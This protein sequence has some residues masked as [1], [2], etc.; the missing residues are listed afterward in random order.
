MRPL[1]L[2]VRTRHADYQVDTVVC[3]EHALWSFERA[4]KG[5]T[6]MITMPP[7]TAQ[8]QFMLT[9]VTGIAGGKKL[10]TITISV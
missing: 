9:A 7:N 10:N 5:V 4:G 3:H 6:Y 2:S 8:L 1:E